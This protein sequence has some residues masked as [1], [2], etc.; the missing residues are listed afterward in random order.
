MHTPLVG[1]SH[2]PC[3]SEP[4]GP[5]LVLVRTIRKGKERGEDDP[6]TIGMRR[7]G[8]C[9]LFFPESIAKGSSGKSLEHGHCDTDTYTLTLPHL[10][11]NTD[12]S[13]LTLEH[14]RFHT[15]T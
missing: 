3:G 6:V 5:V 13:T 2:L 15:D 7:G 10:H 14:L 1:T 4:A 12:I 11:L 8:F 9:V